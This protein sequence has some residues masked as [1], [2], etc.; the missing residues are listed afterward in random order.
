MRISRSNESGKQANK[1]LLVT[2]E[3]HKDTTP[4]AYIILIIFYNFFSVTIVFEVKRIK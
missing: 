1:L 3:T 4:F 2:F